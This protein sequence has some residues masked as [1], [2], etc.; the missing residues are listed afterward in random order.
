MKRLLKS[1]E[2]ASV[3]L[4]EALQPDNCEVSL[5]LNTICF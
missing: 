5:P 4:E 2:Q 1:F 3:F